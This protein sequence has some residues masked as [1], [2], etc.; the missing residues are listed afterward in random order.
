MQPFF[1]ESLTPA[2]KV[3]NERELFIF[4]CLFN[5]RKT[6]PFCWNPVKFLGVLCNQLTN[7]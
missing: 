4:V 5:T 2:V 7:F 1:Y 3:L 6:H